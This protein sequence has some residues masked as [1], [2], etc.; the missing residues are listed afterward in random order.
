MENKILKLTDEDK[1]RLLRAKIAGIMMAL[2][3]HSTMCLSILNLEAFKISMVGWVIVLFWV[4]REIMELTFGKTDPKEKRRG[5][6]LVICNL[7][8]KFIKLNWVIAIICAII[9]LFT[10]STPLKNVVSTLGFGLIMHIMFQW[11]IISEFK[12]DE[13]K[14]EISGE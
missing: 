11:G 13:E 14:Y 6:R 3:M 10:S 12:K 8:R 9:V 5:Q 4:A 7:S 1:K 2:L